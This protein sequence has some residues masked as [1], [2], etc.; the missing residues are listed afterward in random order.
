MMYVSS[1]GQ[2]I[3]RGLV[4]KTGEVVMPVIVV[5]RLRLRDPALLDE[6][7]ASRPRLRPKGFINLLS[8]VRCMLDWA[9]AQ[10]LIGVS[11]LR[12]RRRCASSES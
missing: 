12:A 11:P 7:L 8:V 6:F 2:E 4:A 1:C 10:Q 3:G 9:V 5:T